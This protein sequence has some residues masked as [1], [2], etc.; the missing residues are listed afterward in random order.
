VIFRDEL[1]ALEAEDAKLRIV[2]ATTRGSAQ[3]AGDVE[4]R[5][6]ADRLRAL[7]DGWGERDP[8]VYVCGANGF[9]ET[10]TRVLVE[11][12]LRPASIRAE[13]YGGTA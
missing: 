12:G 3:R 1:L 7:L 9:V 8:R 4:G 11:R 2:L 5:L 13:R 10:M 6:D